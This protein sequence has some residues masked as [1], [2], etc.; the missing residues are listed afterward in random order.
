MDRQNVYEVK[1][2]RNTYDIVSAD[3][4][5]YAFIGDRIYDTFDK[6]I[7]Q[8]DAERLQEYINAGETVPMSLRTEQGETRG[9]VAAFYV[10][11][12]EP[13]VEIKMI[14]LDRVQEWAQQ[15]RYMVGKKNGILGMYGDYYFDYE[16][17]ADNVRIYASDRFEQNVMSVTFAEFEQKLLEQADEKNV[18]DVKN[19]ISTL[20]NGVDRFAFNIA[21][22]ALNLKDT[23]YTLVKGMSY[24]EDG[25]H[26]YSTGYI[27]LWDE[28]S[29]MSTEMPRAMEKDYL[30][31]V[32]T[33]AEIT[34]LAINI[35]D[36]KKTYNVTLAIIDIDYF[37]KVND[38]YGHMMG[39]EVL[40]RVASVIEK[41]V[42]DEGL[43][44]RFG[45]DEFLVIFYN[46]YDMEN[47]RERLRS[48][49]SSV[50]SSFLKKDDEDISITLSI[51]CAAYPKDA[52]NYEDLFFLAD[53]ALYRAKEKG[54]NR[55]I[56]YDC[57]KH[58][59]LE[60]LRNTKMSVNTLNSRGNMTPAELVCTMMDRVYTGE[61]YPLDKLLDDVALNLNIQRVM[62]YAGRPYRLVGVAGSGRL[63][64]EVIEA[65][66]D[67]L[68]A[69]ALLKRYD[70][71]GVAVIDNVKRFENS[72]PTLYEQLT[73]QGILSLIHIRFKDK[74]GEEAL[75][76]LE[77]IKGVETWNRSH[78]PYFRLL[79]KLLSEYNLIETVS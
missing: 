27:H 28:R 7:E 70:D 26:I 76:S 8:S 31:G 79:A 17:E 25:R 5:F 52:D 35:V 14:P 4:A 66:R 9:C 20:R 64:N 63:S 33:K 54:R 38:T 12:G 43:V 46:A 49:K 75:L 18:D 71:T 50:A 42:R 10:Q 58:G 59:S 36:V 60:Q 73:K 19:L 72:S 30:T 44:G 32:L 40:K 15:N 65:T 29:A 68:T 48:I 23:A 78:V 57:E 51:G 53:S 77:Y 56:I 1:I 67:Y 2:N 13:I 11:E 3:T 62:L 37:K 24:Y 6:L 16:V 74:D 55:Y 69:P 61:N 22:D 47:M 39:D 34:N 41:E 45:G 21:G